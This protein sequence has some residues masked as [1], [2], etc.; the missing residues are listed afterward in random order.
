[1]HPNPSP[2]R[3]RAVIIALLLALVAPT[4]SARWYAFEAIVF[5]H[6]QPPAVDE[7]WPVD[8]GLPALDGA[9]ELGD[10]APLDDEPGADTMRLAYRRLGDDEL[11]LTPVWRRL[12]RSRGYR[13]LLHLGWI[14]PGVERRDARAVHLHLAAP[15]TADAPPP[16]TDG[17]ETP[18]P[19]PTLEGTLR[20]YRSRYLHLEADLDYRPAAGGTPG[21]ESAAIVRLVESRRMRSQRLH[22]LDNPWFGILFVARPLADQPPAVEPSSDSADDDQAPAPGIP[23]SP[24]AA[25]VPAAAQ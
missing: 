5:A 16:A 18:T 1:M 23:Q 12:A 10:S 25:A 4:A 24:P 21:P 2:N 11:E 3:A 22:H 13:P 9:V 20:V 15:G 17:G 8:P 19:A 14:Q 7:Q 6:L